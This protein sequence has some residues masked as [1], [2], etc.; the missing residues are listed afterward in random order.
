MAVPSNKI[1][2]A[3]PEVYDGSAKSFKDWHRQLRIYFLGR[4]ITDDE[5]RITLALSYM[6][7]GLASAWATRY[8][9][10]ALANTPF[11]LGTWNVFETE[12]KNTFEDKTHA[13]RARQKLETF[14][15]GAHRIDNFIAHFESLT[16]D[17][18]LSDDRELIRLLKYNLK[19]SIVDW[20]YTLDPI[21]TTYAGWK[22]KV[23]A[24]RQ[25]Q[26]ERQDL[27]NRVLHA[28]PPVH[29]PLPPLPA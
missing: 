29:R 6:K 7:T 27:K 17:A 13:E 10:N 8:F 28:S 19:S 4:K 24:F 14:Q 11:T 20:M 5:E 1:K 18:G 23:L 9:D 2:V 25:N 15:Q 22:G 12:L 3:E 26:E 16:T 21:P